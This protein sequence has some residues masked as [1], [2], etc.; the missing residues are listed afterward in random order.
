M[1]ENGMAYIGRCPGC[2][3]IVMGIVDDP[4]YKKDIAKQVADGIKNGLQVER[5]PLPVKFARCKCEDSK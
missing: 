3:N 5:V 2:Q 1:S 4:E